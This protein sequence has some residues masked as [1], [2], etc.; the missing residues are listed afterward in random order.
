[1]QHNSESPVAANYGAS[2]NDLAGCSIILGNTNSLSTP[3]EPVATSVTG[4]RQDNG[5]PGSKAGMSDLHPLDHPGILDC[6]PHQWSP[7]QRQIVQLMDDEIDEAPVN[8]FLRAV[9]YV[10][11]LYRGRLILKQQAVD[12]LQD[13]AVFYGLAHYYGHDA[14]QEVLAEAFDEAEVEA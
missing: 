5:R 6:D 7:L 3:Q 1:M 4:V 2:K 12:L 9:G 10:R 14:I 13:T 11:G 8:A